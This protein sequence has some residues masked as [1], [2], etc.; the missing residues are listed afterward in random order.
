MNPTHMMTENP[1][2]PASLLSTLQKLSQRQFSGRL[3]VHN[4]SE[5]PWQYFFRFGRLVYVS[6][7]TNAQQRWRAHL[8]R[9]CPMFDWQSFAKDFPAQFND[10]AWEYQ[11]LCTMVRH[12]YLTGESA[13][14]LVR[15]M[16]T[17][18]LCEA[19]CSRELYFEIDPHNCLEAQ[20]TLFSFKTVLENLRNYLQRIQHNRSLSRN[21]VCDIA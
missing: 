17:E 4:D 20:F 8:L 21:L 3:D 14:E 2:L 16:T 9:V 18:V 10:A 5:T 1:T 15:D 6:G 11:A 19:A 13:V 12:G 7:G